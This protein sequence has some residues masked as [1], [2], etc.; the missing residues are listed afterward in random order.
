MQGWSHPLL[1]HQW[2]ARRTAIRA[3]SF[4]LH[5]VPKTVDELQVQPRDKLSLAAEM[6]V[7]PVF[8]A[9]ASHLHNLASDMAAGWVAALHIE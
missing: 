6:L 8:Q 5:T 9:A 4:P 1:T 7:L 2:Q 3:V